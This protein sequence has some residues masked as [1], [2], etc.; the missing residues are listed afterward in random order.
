VGGGHHKLSINTQKLSNSLQSV[1]TQWCVGP[2][3]SSPLFIGATILVH[4]G[5]NLWSPSLGCHTIHFGTQ[6]NETPHL[7]LYFGDQT[8]EAPACTGCVTLHF[9]LYHLVEANQ[10]TH[11]VLEMNL[12]YKPLP[13]QNSEDDWSQPHV[14]HN[15]IML[16]WLGF[17]SK[18]TNQKSWTSNTCCHQP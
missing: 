15:R 6:I 18:S 2:H 4:K 1:R 10:S 7:T 16:S 9:I 14:E 3:K 12:K 11:Q 8:C 5:S 13:I 17:I